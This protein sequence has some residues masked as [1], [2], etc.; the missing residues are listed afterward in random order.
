VAVHQVGFDQTVFEIFCFLD[1]QEGSRLPFWIFKSA[2]FIGSLV[3]MHLCR[4]S[5]PS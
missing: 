2:H 4:A 1:F 5:T 3:M